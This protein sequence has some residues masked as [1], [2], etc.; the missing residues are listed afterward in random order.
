MTFAPSMSKGS[1]SRGRFM[2]F[3]AFS[4]TF[5]G[6]LS[7]PAGCGGG[8]SPFP[9][10]TP[11]WG[12]P[13]HPVAPSASVAQPSI[14]GHARRPGR[15]SPRMVWDTWRPILRE[16]GLCPK[17]ATEVHHADPPDKQEPVVWSLLPALLAG[18][19]RHGRRK[20]HAIPQHL[21]DTPHQH[22]CHHQPGDLLPP[23]LLDSLAR[24][25]ITWQVPDPHRGLD[26]VVPQV[27][28]R[29]PTPDV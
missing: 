2:V 27:P 5:L 23:T 7:P 12:L 8:S 9:T 26:Q 16:L 21:V 20:G 15:S 1:L 22:A 6:E 14:A 13:A 18:L 10:F 11:R 25:A 24:R 3:P 4:R 17:G 28:I 19:L 29:P